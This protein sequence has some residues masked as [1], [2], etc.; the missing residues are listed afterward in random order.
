MNQSERTGLYIGGS[1]RR[2]DSI[3]PS[4]HELAGIFMLAFAAAALISHPAG[5]LHTSVMDALTAEAPAAATID[6]IES[7]RIRGQ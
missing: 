4:L 7:Y 5:P 2:E 6:G 3:M 1:L